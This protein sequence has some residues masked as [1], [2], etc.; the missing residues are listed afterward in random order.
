MLLARIRRGKT[1]LHGDVQ[2]EQSSDQ[3]RTGHNSSLSIPKTKRLGAPRRLRIS[4]R[5]QERRRRSLSDWAARRR[6]LVVRARRDAR[7]HRRAYSNQRKEAHQS[8]T[9]IYA[10]RRFVA[11]AFDL[12]V[13]AAC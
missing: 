6:I 12:Y 3:K 8:W 5:F 11:L 1:E 10:G 7:G 4:S 13:Y 2:D 9:N